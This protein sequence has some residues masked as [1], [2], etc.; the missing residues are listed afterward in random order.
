MNIAL[1]VLL[2]P[3]FIAALAAAFVVGAIALAG[4]AVYLAL[5]AILSALQLPFRVWQAESQP[6]GVPHHEV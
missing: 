6:Q 4:I 2:L 1:I 5:I 3:A